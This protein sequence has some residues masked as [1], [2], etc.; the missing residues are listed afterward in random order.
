VSRT[1]FAR[2]AAAI[3]VLTLVVV[4]LGAYVRLSDAGLGCPDW[5]GCY[6]R[7]VAPTSAEAVAAANAVHPTRPVHTAKAW[8]EMVHRYVASALGLAILVLAAVA[9]R[10]RDHGLPVALPTTLLVLVVFQGLLGMWTVTHLV[11]PAIVT[12]HLAGALATLMLSWWLALRTGGWLLATGER[13]APLLRPVAIGAF[14]LVALQILLGGW[15]STHYAALA[16]PEF[17]TCHGGLWWPPADFAAGFSPWRPLGVD[18][19]FGTLDSP[20]RTAIHLAHRIG[21]LAVLV[22]VGALAIRV[23]RAA[24]ALPQRRLGAL[25]LT[26]LAA[27]VALGIGNVLGR[28]ALPVAVAH[29]AGAAILLATV[30]TLIHSLTP[31]RREPGA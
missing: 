14:A 13:R 20:A 10:R 30:L 17:P 21:A 28:L 27:Q 29:T 18:Y 19:E 31:L 1:A 25:L 9:W 7:L 22:A 6:G 24:P 16:C 23:M 26:V 2:F 4:V 8:K 3:A 15:T 5:P 12:A 11:N